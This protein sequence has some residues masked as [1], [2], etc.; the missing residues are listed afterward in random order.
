MQ[1]DKTLKGDLGVKLLAT[2][3]PA[4]SSREYENQGNGGCRYVP[5]DLC[6]T[7]T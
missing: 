7:A 5:S 1:I 4:R 2:A 6:T 3:P